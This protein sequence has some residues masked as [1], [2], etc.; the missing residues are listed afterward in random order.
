MRAGRTA[1]TRDDVSAFGPRALDEAFDP[2][3]MGERGERSDLGLVGIGQ[4]HPEASRTLRHEGEH[5]VVDA[6]LDEEAR[7]RNARLTRA[8]EDAVGHRR[9]GRFD[10]GIR[11]HDVR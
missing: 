6:A 9:H 10:I 7:A 8:L 3:P 11:E 5:A 1:P 4:V 2:I